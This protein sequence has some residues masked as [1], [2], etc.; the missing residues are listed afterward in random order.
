MRTPKLHDALLVF[1]SRLDNQNPG[2]ALVSRVWGERMVD[3]G[4]WN[5]HATPVSYTSLKLLQEDDQPPETGPYAVFAS[6]EANPN[7][8]Q[9]GA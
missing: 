5:A 8:F 7:V 2:V 1:T 6:T 9:A 3:A 4:G